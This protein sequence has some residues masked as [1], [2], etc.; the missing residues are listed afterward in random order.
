VK[1]VVHH[2]IADLH[3][4][5]MNKSFLVIVFLF[6]FQL[7]LF[8]QS[9]SDIQNIKVDNLS[10]AQ[11]EQLVRRA[12]TQ[13]LSEQQL[14]EHGGRKGYASRRGGEI[15]TKIK[16][17]QERIFQTRSTARSGRC[18]GFPNAIRS[19]LNCG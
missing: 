6:F 8:G 5:V 19:K 17:H 15:K 4:I 7:T 1:F 11:I 13:G 9:L 16:C 14:L 18:C 12:E 3:S 10:D 2:S